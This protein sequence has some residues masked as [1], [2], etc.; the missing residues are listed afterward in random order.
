MASA[1]PLHGL[2]PRRKRWVL[3][4]MSGRPPINRPA[5]GPAPQLDLTLI[6][7]G[8]LTRIGKSARAGVAIGDDLLVSTAIRLGLVGLVTIDKGTPQRVRIRRF[9]Q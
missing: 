6:E 4:L 3:P 1:Q 7:R 9:S 8:A 5:S 2:E